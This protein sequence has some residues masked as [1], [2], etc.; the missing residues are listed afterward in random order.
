MA[1]VS[2]PRAHHAALRSIAL[3]AG[4]ALL[5][6]AGGML[7]SFAAGSWKEAAAGS[8]S[9]A[10]LVCPPC[11]E[12]RQPAAVQNHQHDAGSKPAAGLLNCPPQPDCPAAEP[13][14]CPACTA[15][16]AG[17]DCPP[18][19][20][21]DAAQQA[22]EAAAELLCQGPDAIPSVA[23]ALEASTQAV[24]AAVNR[25]FAQWAESGFTLEDLLASADVVGASGV[26]DTFV[27]VEVYNGTVTFPWRF[28]GVCEWF[29]NEW[30]PV[31]KDA[32]ERGMQEGRLRVPEGMP[33]I[34][35][36]NDFS[37]CH[38][39]SEDPPGSRCPGP[40]LSVIRHMDHHDVLV[41]LFTPMRL[42]YYE[43]YF[44]PWQSKSDLAFFRGSPWCS[45]HQLNGTV[46]LDSS[47]CSR[48]SLTLLSNAHPGLLNVSLIRPYGR[49]T[50]PE[51]EPASHHD[52]ATFK[53]LLQLDGITASRRY[54]TLLSMNSLVLKQESPWS[55]WYYHALQP[56]VHHL[57]F[58]QSS[59]EDVLDLLRTLRVNPANQLTAQRIAANANAFAAAW[60][61]DEGQFRYWQLLIDRY[62][63]LYRGPGRPQAL[64]AKRKAEEL[65]RKVSR[66]GTEA[67]EE[68]DAAG[69]PDCWGYSLDQMDAALAKAR[70][71]AQGAE[72]GAA[73]EA[74]GAEPAAA[75]EAQGAEP[76]TATE[77]QGAEPAAATEAQG[78]E[79][80]ATAEAQGAEPTAATEAQGAEPTA[81]T[82]AQGAEPTASAA[83]LK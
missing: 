18:P 66:V 25:S 80:T 8:H 63:E 42:S 56:C 65:G 70:A 47:N 17:A 26:H 52:H 68:C 16:L 35:N 74:Q 37:G 32:W 10:A 43:P 7:Q 19:A 36:V 48:E 39:N 33:F 44:V 67:Q 46:L 58:W 3:I 12:A 20:D 15:C 49:V 40:V 73:A 50:T 62:A 64:E 61:D 29:C 51:G 79:P 31:L 13:A 83:S 22:A 82:E 78:A 4:V 75:A 21:A 9:C 55:E 30:V 81:S 28:K 24:M 1:Q 14:G 23:D 71:E 57:P 2:T 54:G 76:A 59:E 34:W 53:Y 60:L 72:P 69:R 41:P 5:F 38:G 11:P 77:A 6:A 45:N 27:W